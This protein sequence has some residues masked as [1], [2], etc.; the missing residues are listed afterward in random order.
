M[1]DKMVA[2]LR[3]EAVLA[4]EFVIHDKRCAVSDGYRGNRCPP[5]RETD[6]AKNGF[7]NGAK[8][9]SMLRWWNDPTVFCID[10]IDCID[11]L[12]DYRKHVFSVWG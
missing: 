3:P 10:C 6:N 11:F 2:L 12:A 4:G 5:I 7:R 8:G 1:A 9:F